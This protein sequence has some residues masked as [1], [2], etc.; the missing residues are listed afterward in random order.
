MKKYVGIAASLLLMLVMA[1]CN[2]QLEQTEPSKTP[3]TPTATQAPTTEATTAPTEAPAAPLTMALP[4]EAEQ[5]TVAETMVFQG[6]ID[7]RYEATIN[8][9]TLQIDENGSF[10]YEAQ[11]EVGENTFDITYLDE[12]VTYYVNRNYTT[13]WYGHADGYTYCS[14]AYVYA[15][16]YAREGSKVEITFQGKT[17]PVEASANQLASGAE[18]LQAMSPLNVLSRGYALC[19]NDTGNLI[20]SASQ[21]QKGDTITVILEQGRL[22]AAV[23]DREEETWKQKS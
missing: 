8:G 5:T 16:L 6:T 9:E 4:L 7:P 10:T 2:Q 3:T 11:L 15:E 20:R 22:R 19:E 18:R 1:G 23:T 13:A 17:A 21:V 14:G 12:T